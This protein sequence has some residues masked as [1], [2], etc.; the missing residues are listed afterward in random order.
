MD[1]TVEAFIANQ[2]YSNSNILTSELSEGSPNELFRAQSS[3]SSCLERNGGVTSS[4]SASTKGGNSESVSEEENIHRL[5]EQCSLF[6]D[7]L[8]MEQHSSGSLQSSSEYSSSDSE[9]SDESELSD[10]SDECITTDTES[11]EAQQFDHDNPSRHLYDAHLP[12]IQS[13]DFNPD[14]IESESETSLD[15]ENSECHEASTNITNDSS[16]GSEV[17]KLAVASG[18]ATNF[19][20]HQ[21]SVESREKICIQCCAWPDVQKSK[22]TYLFIGA[23]FKIVI[24]S[25]FYLALDNPVHYHRDCYHL[26]SSITETELR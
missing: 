17:P 5:L 12:L 21:L 18:A 4:S 10:C 15:Q 11:V 6:I 3:G 16:E 25:I 13:I 14:G 7:E 2:S 9:C 26:L 1:P 20:N 19:L 22:G 23:V 24:H 8:L